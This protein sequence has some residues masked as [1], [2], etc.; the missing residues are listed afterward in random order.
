MA[1]KKGKDLTYPEFPTKFV[2]KEDSKQWVPR[3]RGISLGRLQYVSPGCGELYYMRVLLTKQ[4]GCDSFESIRTVKGVVYPNFHDVCEAFGLLED[5][6]EYIDGLLD[7]CELGSGMQLR[8]LF[9]RLLL[10]NMISRPSHVW[11]N[12]WQLL[13]DGILCDRR[14]A[15]NIPDL[16]IDDG[17]LQNLCLMEIENLLQSNGRS[18][19]EFPCMP[20]PHFAEIVNFEN[21]FI[22]D[23][24]NYNKEE[25]MTLHDELVRTLTTEQKKVYKKVLD[26]VR[27]KRGG[28]F[29]SLRSRGEIVLNVAS[30]GIASLL[31][32]GGRT[33]H[34]RFSIPISI[35]EISTC[36]LRQGSLKAELLKKASLIIWDEAPM[37][38]R[39][40]F[41]AL[42]KSLNDIM[43]TKIEFGHDIPP[44]GK[45][46]F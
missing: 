6:G 26:A 13:S 46:C 37:L 14:K 23:E 7:S 35:N 1:P 2:Y 21:K 31:L 42:D 17:N 8:K 19:K 27:R 40:C 18:L 4:K 11:K 44:G 45:L 38:N 9:S 15:L 43:K 29:F 33:A 36:N 20:Y 41:E 12:S 22:A 25:M 30:S 39:H 24:L 16:Q 5:D 3:K 34:S 32:P 28:F 10:S